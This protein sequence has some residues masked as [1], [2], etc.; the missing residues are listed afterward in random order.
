MDKVHIGHLSYV[1]DS[2]IGEDC[3]LGAGTITA[4]YRL[5]AKMVKMMVKDRLVDSGRT[6]LGVVLGDD[7]KA[8]INVLFMPGVKVGSSSQIG[9][10]VIVYRDVP[11]NTLVLLKQ[12]LEERKIP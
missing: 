5:D 12:N 7:V 10:N 8:G 4:N 11:A 1:G 3:N 9:P 6:K 2:I